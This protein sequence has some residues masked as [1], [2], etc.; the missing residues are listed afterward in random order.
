MANPT[1]ENSAVLKEFSEQIERLRH[2]Q[3]D[4]ANT[5]DFFSQQ[6]KLLEMQKFKYSIYITALEATP[7]EATEIIAELLEIV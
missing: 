7:S 2:M 3:A 1:K 4:V 6:T 5:T